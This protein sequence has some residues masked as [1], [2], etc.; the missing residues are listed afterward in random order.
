[1]SPN[2]W[3]VLLLLSAS[4]FLNYFDRITLSVAATDIQRE[5]HISNTELGTLHS[6]FFAAYAICQISFLSGWVVGRFPVGWVMAC[7]FFLWTCAT[8]ATGMMY[9][10]TAII[11]LRVLLGIG[12]SIS[13]PSYSRILASGF[14]E[15][16]RGLANALIDAGTKAAPAAG[17]LLGGLL[18]AHS[19]WRPF[20]LALGG[21]T[22]IWLVPWLRWM[23]RGAAAARED[24]K[25]VPSIA[26]ILPQRSMW[27]AAFGQFCANYF[28]Y[29]LMAWLPAYLEKERHFPKQKMALFAWLP[30]L[31]IAIADIISG[32]A[33]DRLIER[34]HSPTLVR[35]GFAG[36]GMT[37]SCLVI[38][39]ALVRSDTAA[40]AILTVACFIYGIYA[41]QLFAIVQ[42]IAG[43]HAAGKWTSFQ[44]GFA[45]L[46][47]IL[48]PWLTGRVL[49][50]T[51]E[52]YVAFVLAG[53]IAVAGAANWVLGV[54][55]IEPVEFRK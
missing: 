37:G 21:G 24:T 49:D 40:I 23:P 9:A 12:E 41:S 53:V 31:A 19:G 7:G 30:F 54:G 2:Q 48:A 14:P 17:A 46:A 11:V 55:R 51:G 25:L 47:G 15:H 52:F 4:A 38:G 39:V 35:K 13:F 42:A 18:I 3:A 43:P 33:S 20:F 10:F 36:V 1:M 26:A 44:N 29:F 32:W 27:F 28:W 8:A 34:G 16:H 6:A 45:N 50:V 22:L 5:F